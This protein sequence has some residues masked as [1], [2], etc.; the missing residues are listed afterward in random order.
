LGFAVATRLLKSDSAEERARGLERLGKVGTA[1][2]LELLA[3]NLEPGGAKT[4]EERL[5]AVR[6]L[7]RQAGS[8]VARPALARIMASATTGDDDSETLIRT[9]AALALARSGHPDALEL[10]GKALRQEGPV[11]SA[12]ATALAAHP[13]RNLSPVVGARGALTSS[14][15]D[16]LEQL[17]DQRAFA[18]L[19]SFI[20]YGAPEHKAQAAIALTRLGDY[21]TVELARAW[22]AREREPVLR[23]AASQILSLARDP[24]AASAIA[25]LLA[26]PETADAGIELALATPDPALVGALSTLLE[27]ATSGGAPDLIGAIGRAGG[28]AAAKRLAQELGKPERAPAAAYALALSPG[29]AALDTLERALTKSTTRRLAARAAVVRAVTLGETASGIEAALDALVVST[30][31][32]DRAAGAWGHAT[33]SPRRAIVLL[34]R[35]DPVVVRAAARAALTPQVAAAAAERLVGERDPLTRTALAIS[36]ASPEG[37]RHV[38]TRVLSTLVEEGGAAAPVAA[39]ALAAR[40]SEAL[41]PQLRELFDSGDPWIRSHIALG[42]ADSS[43][44]SA[45]GLLAHRFRAEREAGVRH[46]IVVALSRRVESTRVSTLEL[47]ANL[48][49]STPVRQAARRALSGVRLT[50]LP[51][52]AGSFWLQLVDS[53]SLQG[54]QHSAV[55]GTTSG[56]AL[57]VVADPDGLVCMGG[58]PA[59]PVSLR[60]AAA[61]NESKASSR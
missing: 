56:V 2:A 57:P 44:P 21:E 15:I 17:R 23:L 27:R 43:D 39:R 29:P 33:L 32:A 14:L 55:L 40:D 50:S 11:A 46:A 36:L 37:A 49:P 48:D 12:A 8:P 31:A 35:A 30:N 13:P 24:G 6:A 28:P 60:L 1:A 9:T 42:L 47:A 20:K 34:R 5:T 54:R 7:A 4:F 51:K 22:L 26:K 3:K 10:L 41:R 19:R 16:G 61:A 45:V 59:G 52:G 25:A 38:P 53:E 58:L 18:T